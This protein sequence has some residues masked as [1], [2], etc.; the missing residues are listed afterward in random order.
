MDRI[1]KSRKKRWYMYFCPFVYQRKPVVLCV[2]GLI[3]SEAD[4]KT[5]GRL[6]SSSSPLSNTVSFSRFN[7]DPRKVCVITISVIFFR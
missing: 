3:F 6:S 7:S 5:A 4:K 2:I 1:I